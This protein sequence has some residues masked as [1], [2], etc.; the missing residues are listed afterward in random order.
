MCSLLGLC[1]HLIVF[2]DLPVSK[3]WTIA[4]SRNGNCEVALPCSDLD[5]PALRPPQAGRRDPGIGRFISAE[6]R[7]DGD[8]PMPSGARSRRGL[9]R[10]QS[11][12][13]LSLVYDTVSS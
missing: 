6:E 4:L 2:P 9:V 1:P 13:R 12:S 5:E 3:T 11:G 10:D 8:R 7:R